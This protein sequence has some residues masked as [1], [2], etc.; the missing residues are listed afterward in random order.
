MPR[1]RLRGDPPPKEVSVPRIV[2]TALREDRARGPENRNAAMVVIVKV[3]PGAARRT[4]EADREGK[5]VSV[6]DRRRAAAAA[7]R[8]A[9]SA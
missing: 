8:S 3:V 5:A 7:E 1:P 2:R 6:A 9:G 4:E